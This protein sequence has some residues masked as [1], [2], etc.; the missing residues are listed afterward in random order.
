[1]SIRDLVI[2]F[3][4]VLIGW[5][6]FLIYK[7]RDNI[8]SF[9]YPQ[10]WVVIEMIE[11]DNSVSSWLQRKTSDLS[12]EFNNGDYFM[13]DSSEEVKKSNVPLPNGG[14]K[15]V[16]INTGKK[17]FPVYREGRISKFYYI[18]GNSYP[19]DFKH[20]KPV[21]NPQLLK[22]I[23]TSRMYDMMFHK[24]QD[25]IMESIIKYAPI[26]LLIVVGVMLFMLYNKGS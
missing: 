3:I 15:E 13:F 16:F 7:F 14:F 26:V 22:Q 20:L 1:M 11:S 23:K 8:H 21:G 5:I 6:V 24:P 17:F 25:S 9:I 18:E 12:F 19:L 2:I 4:L 10:K